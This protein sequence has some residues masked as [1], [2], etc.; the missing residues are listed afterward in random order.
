LLAKSCFV[1][2]IRYTVPELIGRTELARFS[3]DGA[4]VGER[5][6]WQSEAGSFGNLQIDSREEQINYVTQT[7]TDDG[8]A[9]AG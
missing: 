4:R 8:D 1:C 6:R 7:F 3:P 5:R 9:G 2:K